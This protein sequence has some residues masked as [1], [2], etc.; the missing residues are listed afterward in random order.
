MWTL[1]QRGGSDPDRLLPWLL[2]LGLTPETAIQRTTDPENVVSV[3][4]AVMALIKDVFAVPLMPGIFEGPF[5]L[6]AVLALG[7]G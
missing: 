3:E 7:E 1:H 5:P 6:G 4:E 2:R